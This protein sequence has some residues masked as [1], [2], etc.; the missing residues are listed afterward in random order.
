[1]SAMYLAD[2][3][4]YFVCAAAV[5]VETEEVGSKGLFPVA[6][7]FQNSSPPEMTLLKRNICMYCDCVHVP[8]SHFNY[9]QCDIVCLVRSVGII[10]GNPFSYICMKG[11]T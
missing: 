6:H 4:R 2:D 8:I 11:C 9:A 7:L 5:E 10:Q 1:M 3:W